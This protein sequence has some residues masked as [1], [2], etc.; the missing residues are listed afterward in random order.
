MITSDELH[1]FVIGRNKEVTMS[2]VKEAVEK[3]I[4]PPHVIGITRGKE[5]LP[6]EAFAIDFFE[7]KSSEQNTHQTFAS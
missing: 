1:S 4:I 5:G 6:K 7:V 2:K 3:E